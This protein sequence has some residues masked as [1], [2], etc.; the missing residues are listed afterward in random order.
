MAGVRAFIVLQV[1]TS[2]KAMRRK[3]RMTEKREGNLCLRL[4]NGNGKAWPTEPMPREGRQEGGCEKSRM[5]ES[6]SKGCTSV[7]ID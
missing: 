7:R 1:V 4:E 6:R 3:R 2:A 5:D